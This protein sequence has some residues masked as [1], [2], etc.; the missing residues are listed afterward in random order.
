M[1]SDS[2]TLKT[3]WLENNRLKEEIKELKDQ[4]SHLLQIIHALNT[5]QYNLDAITAETDVL[6]L[7]KGILSSA[8]EAVGCNDGSLVLLDPE[9]NE[10]VFIEVMGQGRERLLGLRIPAH[11]GVAGWTITEKTPAL[12][13]EAEYDSRWSSMVDEKIGFQTVSM[14]SVPL[15]DGDRPLG[16]IQVLNPL[17]GDPFRDSDLDIMMLVARLASLALLKAEKLGQ[18]PQEDRRP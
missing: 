8:L 14:V 5:L 6:S 17:S 16:V 9:K 3:L 4:V 12:I 18:R 10:L 2:L 13:A 1:S 11:E 15:L 7:V